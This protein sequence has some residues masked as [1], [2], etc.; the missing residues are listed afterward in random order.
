MRPALSYIDVGRVEHLRRTGPQR[1]SE[2]SGTWNRSSG[3]RSTCGG[4]AGGGCC[5]IAAG[6]NAWLGATASRINTSRTVRGER[7]PRRIGTSLSFF[8]KVRGRYSTATV[9]GS[10]FGVSGSGS[11]FRFEVRLPW[12]EPSTEHPEPEPG[13][14]NV[15]PRTSPLALRIRRPPEGRAG[16]PCSRLPR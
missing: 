10:G 14:Q 15:E 6:R 8:G 7:T 13:T 3:M 4:A 1:D 16:C 2:P 9:L 12:G 5:C 11:R